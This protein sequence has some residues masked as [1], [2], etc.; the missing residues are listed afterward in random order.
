M[1][2]YHYIYIYIYICMYGYMYVY[3]CIY[4]YIF[5]YIYINIYV[6]ICIYLHEYVC[7]YRYIQYVPYCQQVTLPSSFLCD[8]VRDH[9]IALDS[10]HRGSVRHILTYRCH[11]TRGP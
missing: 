7:A 9:F 4:M 11:A 1:Y 2:V 6:Y 3:V 5:I 10:R 8:Q